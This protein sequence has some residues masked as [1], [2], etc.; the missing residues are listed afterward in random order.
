MDASARAGL[1]CRTGAVGRDLLATSFCSPCLVLRN[2]CMCLC[3]KTT[4][5]SFELAEASLLC[6][7]ELK[8]QTLI[9][10]VLYPYARNSYY[11]TLK[12]FGW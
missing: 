8:N 3:M 6:S 7:N 1:R 4:A 9:Y 11:V 10:A 2:L 5:T 12:G